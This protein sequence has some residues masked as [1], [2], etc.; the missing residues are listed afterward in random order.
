MLALATGIPIITT[1]IS[2]Y[3]SLQLRSALSSILCI[4][5][6]VSWGDATFAHKVEST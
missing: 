3:F 1:T 4:H 6:G 2:E 5:T